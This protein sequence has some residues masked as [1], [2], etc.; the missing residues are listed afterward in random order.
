MAIGHMPATYIYIEGSEKGLHFKKRFF[1]V[2]LPR[3]AI[4]VKN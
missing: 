1:K 2:A 4:I 3:R